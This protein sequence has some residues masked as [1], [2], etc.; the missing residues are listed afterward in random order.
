[1]I[2]RQFRDDF[3]PIKSVKELVNYF[4]R[5]RLPP[6]PQEWLDEIASSTKPSKVL[7]NLMRLI[8]KPEIL[9]QLNSTD[10]EIKIPVKPLL[11]EMKRIK[12]DSKLKLSFKKP[13]GEDTLIAVTHAFCPR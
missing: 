11:E 12:L 9:L 1:M 5:K 6:P 2:A 7:S 8:L 3:E 13:K 10:R 4:E